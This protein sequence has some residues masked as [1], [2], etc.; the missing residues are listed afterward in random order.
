M[1]HA[2]GVHELPVRLARTKPCPTLFPQESC[3]PLVAA[4]ISQSCGLH[5]FR[6]VPHVE[7]LLKILPQ[8]GHAVPTSPGKC[9]ARWRLSTFPSFFVE[10]SHPLTRQNLVV[11]ADFRRCLGGGGAYTYAVRRRF[12]KGLQ[13]VNRETET[14][15]LSWEALG[16]RL[17]SDWH[18]SCPLVGRHDQLGAMHLLRCA[19]E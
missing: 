18:S 9:V 6:W 3:V 1:V 11:P 5:F 12:L 14:G 13:L 7:D 19:T 4:I 15:N 8:P 16:I 17:W 2:R 10:N